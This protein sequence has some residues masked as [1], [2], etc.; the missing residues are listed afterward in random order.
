MFTDKKLDT[1]ARDFYG[2]QLAHAASGR[3]HVGPVAFG[4]SEVRWLAEGKLMIAGFK[5]D[6]MGAPFQQQVNAIIGASTQELWAR[7]K[8][9]ANFALT[10][11]PSDCV[12]LPSGY[13]FLEFSPVDSKWLR[14][15]VAMKDPV[16]LPK[17]RQTV[18]ALV[19]ANPRLRQTKYEPWLEFL[20]TVA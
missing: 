7:A 8:A 12:V 13:I 2:S 11:K 20:Q 15:G 16:E 17:V 3:A 10:L 19:D 18:S 4:V 1:I 5:Y 14:W 6:P 9:S